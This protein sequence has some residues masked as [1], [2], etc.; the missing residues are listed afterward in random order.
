MRVLA[1]DWS[2]A[3]S[4]SDRKIWLAEARGGV[5][6]RLESERTRPELITYIVEEAARDPDMVVGFDFAFSMPM[7]Y[8]EKL[9]LSSAA[10]LWSLADIQ[11]EDWLEACEAPF[12]GRRGTKRPSLIDYL[13]VTDRLDIRGISPKSVFQL[14]GPGHVGTGSIRGWPYLNAL[15]RGGFC[16]WP[17]DTP[18]PPIALEIYPRVLTGPVKKSSPADR[19][20]YLR[21]RYPAMDR[22]M[23]DLAASTDDAFDATVS[24]L[25]MADHEASFLDLPQIDDRTT[26]LEGRIWQPL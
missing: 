13:R 2:G 22:Q 15:R 12:W 18:Q 19:E 25:V 21:E 20:R 23:S 3:L 6:L 14:A 1:V 10:E 9:S 8:L 17:F 11:A 4:G 5:L 24:A 26:L 7:W 16:I